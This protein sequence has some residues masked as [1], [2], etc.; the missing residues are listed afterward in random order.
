MRQLYVG[1]DISFPLYRFTKLKWAN[2]FFGTGQ[3]RLGTLF[4]YA[5]NEAYGK[6]IHDRHEGYYAYRVPQKEWKNGVP[7]MRFVLA[8]NNLLLCMTTDYDERYYKEFDANCCIKIN[9]L[10]FFAEIDAVLESGF[11]NLLLRK[12]IYYDKGRWDCVPDYEDF[13]GVMKDVSFAPQREV[14]ALWEPVEYPFKRDPLLRM[15]GDSCEPKHPLYF[16]DPLKEFPE[17]TWYQKIITE[18][19][20]WLKPTTIF[21]PKAIKHCDLIRP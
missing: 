19:W 7:E 16:D 10:D 20:N 3:L 4:D 5:K 18:E 15:S 2:C 13:A 8:R 9:S 12:V 6:A 21:A 17:G 11:T 14:R 1:K